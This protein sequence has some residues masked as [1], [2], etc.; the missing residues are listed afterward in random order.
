MNIMYIDFSDYSYVYD[1][2]CMFIL[3]PNLVWMNLIL[4]DISK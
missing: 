1:C 4:D 3:F 2:I